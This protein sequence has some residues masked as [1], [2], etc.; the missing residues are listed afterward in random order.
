MFVCFLRGPEHVFE[1]TNPAYL[2]LVGH[3]DVIGRSVREAIPEAESQGFLKLLDKVFTSAE[4][5]VGRG[6]PIMLEPSPG[7]PLV[8]RY[9]DFTYEPI[10]ETD[11]S[12]S[13]IF[14]VGSDMTEQR[15]AA[16]ER[17]R[18]A[19]IVEQTGDFI[20]AADMLGRLLFVNDA[21]Q[22][23]LGISDE[24]LG[25]IASTEFFFPEDMAFVMSTIAPALMSS[26][27]WRGDM[28][29]RHFST[30]EAIPVDYHVFA[31]RDP[32][33]NEMT[34]VASVTRDLRGLQRLVATA[35]AAE[36]DYR[37]LTN[38]IPVQIWTATPSGEINFVNQRVLEYF[39]RTEADVLASGWPSGLHP[40]DVERSMASWDESVRTGQLLETEFRL[41]RAAD[42]TYRW[43]IARAVARRNAHGA[44]EK[45]YGTNTD[46]EES[47][48]TASERDSLIEALEASNKELKRFAYVASHDLKTPLRG[49]GN[50]AQWL[51]EDLADRLDDQTRSH[52]T[53]L[54]G[55]VQRMDA[56]IDGVLKYSRAS[57]G[58]E[59][60]QEVHVRELLEVVVDLLAPTEDVSIDVVD[61]MPLLHTAYV[62]L[63]QVFLNLIGNSIKHAHRE[64]VRI[65][66]GV[67]SEGDFHRFAVTDNGRGID[68]AHHDRI[69][70]LFQTLD[71]PNTNASTGIG[72]SMV[73]R[74]VETRGGKVS[75]DSR[76]GHGSTFYFTWPKRDPEQRTVRHAK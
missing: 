61:D 20:G 23:M 62:A 50:I 6:I 39:E 65:T 76:L 51:E 16:S 56:L 75:V 43:H 18:L 13:G 63:Q 17:E 57:E 32:A 4:A 26:G 60:I 22:K 19:T 7:A 1:L 15:Q 11:G 36:N 27:R 37:F 59:S 74:I 30:G 42:Q 46:I 12:V 54:R 2:K 8:Q 5:F 48:R 66:V 73:K 49:I 9:L 21:G 35:A 70:G 45:W 38:A 24:R 14:V 31:I 28:R 33:S 40:D 69:W 29:M 44:I 34:G 25:T 55:R 10:V 53:L 52:L 3:R 71:S 58:I 64:D 47:K 68:A 41:R 72:L 67:T